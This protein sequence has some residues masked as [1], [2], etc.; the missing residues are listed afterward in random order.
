MANSSGSSVPDPRYIPRN[1]SI[2]DDDSAFDLQIERKVSEVRM[3]IVPAVKIARRM[4]AAQILAWYPKFRVAARLDSVDHGIVMRREVRMG[5]IGPEFDIAEE[6]HACTVGLVGKEPDPPYE[7]PPLSKEYLAKEKGFERILLRPVATWADKGIDLVLGCE[8]V[9]I[10]PGRGIAV[11]EDGREVCFEKMIW[12]CGGSPRSL[13]CE[14][15]QLS[16]IHAVRTRR[17]V[18][19]IMADLDAGAGKAVIVGGGYIGLEAA[20]GLRKRGCDAVIVESLPRV[21][22]RVAGEQISTFVEGVHRRNGVDFY[23]SATLQKLEGKGGRVSAAI[24]GDGR[25]IDCD[26]VIVGIGIDPDVAPLKEA[27][28]QVAN[29]VSVDEFCRTSLPNIYAIGDCAQHSNEFAG[30][31]QIRLESVQNANDM[32]V[33]A[34]KHICGKE[35]PYKAT[36]W[37]WSNQFDIKLQTVGISTGYDA[38]VLRGRFEDEKFSVIY[39]KEG[40]VIA[41][42]CINAARDYVQ[43][44]KLVEAR[45]S[46]A[47]ERLAD[48][49]TALKMML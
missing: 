21:L 17:D 32:A 3:A 48:V 1:I 49:E 24:L 37:F 13:T 8:V 44:R 15:A 14:G 47:P 12:A 34:A 27:G 19:A 39:L 43:G 28:A 5:N 11:L 23:L 42:D 41:L 36:P 33:T 38:T 22:S 30:G 10:D 46:V 40:R 20:S 26:L 16:G 18:D 6:A 2:A 31:A 29:G 7:R 25:Q 45:A 4:A 9:T 35:E